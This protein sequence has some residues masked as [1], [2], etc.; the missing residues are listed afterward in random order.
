MENRNGLLVAMDLA[1]ATGYA[2]RQSALTMLDCDLPRGRRRTLGADAG[3]DTS[4]FVADC[5]QRR[6][7]PHV[8]QNRNRRRS[9]IDGRTTRASG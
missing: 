4:D 6:V 1:Q 2:E 7:S 9:A 8:A 5:R 3:Y